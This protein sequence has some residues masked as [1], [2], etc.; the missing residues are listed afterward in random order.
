MIR[1][2]DL[3]GERLFPDTDP[4]FFFAFFQDAGQFVQIRGVLFPDGRS[5]LRAKLFSKRNLLIADLF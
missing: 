3:P 4:Q 1:D 2:E 5:E